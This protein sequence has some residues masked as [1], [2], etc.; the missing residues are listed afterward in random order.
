MKSLDPR[1]TIYVNTQIVDMPH[2]AEFA[3]AVGVLKLLGDVTRLQLLH[4]LTAGEFSVA[5]LAATVEVPGP[6]V[7]QHLA[8]LRL[9]GLVLTRRDG[10]RIFYRLI[11]GHVGA[12]VAEA[13]L[14]A[15]H[16]V[17][18]ARHHADGTG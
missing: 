16:V 5:E 15:D 17:G 6:S 4:V 10:N 3:S 12:L 2:V 11:N 9:G 8:K 13:L 1:Y 14:Q 18:G 7:S